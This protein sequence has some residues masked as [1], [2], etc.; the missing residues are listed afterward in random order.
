MSYKHG[1][2][3]LRRG[4]AA[5]WAASQ[6]QPGG[7]VLRLGE[8]GYEKDTGKLKIGDGVTPW[9]SLVY[10]NAGAT[11]D[12]EDIEDI[13]GDGF[14]VAG[15]GIEIHY[16]DL[17]NSLT[18]STSGVSFDGH[19][20]VSTDITD[21]TSFGRNILTASSYAAQNKLGWQEITTSFTASAGGQ[22]FVKRDTGAI[23]ASGLLVTISDP[24]GLSSPGDS[25]IVVCYGG[26]PI[27]VGGINYGLDSSNSGI[28]LHRTFGYRPGS[29][30]EPLTV[31][32]WSTI[33]FNNHNHTASQITDFNSSVSGLLPVKDIVG[34]TDIS[35]SS[36]SGIYTINSSNSVN[37][38]TKEPDGFVNRSDSTISF[39][40]SSRSPEA[41]LIQSL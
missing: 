16:D 29:F 33:V 1:I 5:E 25:Y 30:P 31:A 14:L 7:E 41:R 38:D 26:R 19:N 37:T 24:S 20:H 3:R 9:N 36:T 23:G 32:E 18:I 40:D 15:T 27:N 12:P 35:I 28:I 34:G 2:I 22:Y 10:F 39:D 17:G 8:P 4:T 11:I 6:P 21:S 13:L